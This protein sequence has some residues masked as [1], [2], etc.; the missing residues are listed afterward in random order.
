MGEPYKEEL[1][2]QLLTAKAASG[3]TFTQ[4]AAEAGL[5]NAYTAQLFFNQAQLKPESAERLQQA[6]PGLSNELV[7]AM[8]LTPIRS[9]NPDLLQEPL[10]Y[11]LYEAVTH[12]GEALKAIT[13]EEFGDGIMS[14]IDFYCTVGKIKGAGGEDRVLL[15]FNGKFLPHVE[16]LAEKNTAPGAGADTQGNHGKKRRKARPKSEE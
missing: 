4:I 7:A 1:V 11:R 16:Q 15:T 10:V 12:Y 5:T 8:S 2:Q 3:K 6:V 13:N 14:A 9:F